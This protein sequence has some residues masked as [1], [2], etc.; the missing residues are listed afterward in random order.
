LALPAC[1]AGLLAWALPSAIQP[2]PIRFHDVAEQSG[3]GAQM[4][5]GGPEKKW[6][7]EANGSGA[8]WLDYDRDGRMDLLIVNGST[9]DDLRQIVAGKVPRAREGSLYLYRNLG[10]GHFQDVTVKAGL[11]NPYWGTGVAIGDFNNDG[12]PDIL[13]TNIG[14]D[15]LFRNNGDGT[16]TEI[17]REAGLSRKVA[18]HTGAAFGDYDGDGKLDLY[19]AGYVDLGALRLDA[20]PPVCNYRGLPGFCGPKGLKGEPDIL[21]HNNGNMTFT[22]VTQKAG[23]TDTGLYHGFTVVFD[24]FNQDGKIDIFVANDSDPNYLYLNQGN[25]VFKEAA[26]PSGLAFNG[27][28]QTQANMGV[29][30]GDIDNDGLIDVLTTT[31][32]EDY[33]PLFKQQSPG[34]YEDVSAKAGLATVTLPWVGWACGFADL[35]NDGSKDLWVANGHVY[36]NADRLATTSYLQS[37]AVLANRGGKFVTVPGAPE[38]GGQGSFRGGC[39]GDFNNDGRIDLLVLPIAG[40]PLL[41][42]NETESHL[43]WIGFQLRGSSGNRDAIGAQVR[44][45]SCGTTQFETMRNGGSYLSGNDPRIHFGLGSC[46]KV[47]RLSI[48]WPGGRRQVLE[49]LA[50]DRYVTVDEPL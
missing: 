25:G 12:Y 21:Y 11:S 36:P 29:A 2:T 50:A 48:R 30:V 32:S 20:E 16:F 34:L 35:D 10:G 4:R 1:G 3:I 24:D 47:D 41:F 6:I 5:C 37:V 42:E 17:G 9:M 27:D 44:I 43:H 38:G 19:V 18:W 13:V 23:V 46:T 49:N 31:F 28:G 45:E 40:R 8:A 26:L 15:L 7:P 14:V 33:F 39:A 22:D